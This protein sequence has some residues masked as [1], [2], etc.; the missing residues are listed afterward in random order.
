MS[1]R[2]GTGA[3]PSNA[4][5]YDDVPMLRHA[6]AQDVVQVHDADRLVGIGHDQRR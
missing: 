5:P 3:T 4:T 6:R 2:V 1:S